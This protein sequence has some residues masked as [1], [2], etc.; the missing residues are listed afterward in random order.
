MRVRKEQLSSFLDFFE[1]AESGRWR[2]H[3]GLANAST[4]ILFN[5]I[6]ATIVVVSGIFGSG[7]TRLC[8]SR[9]VVGIHE[10]GCCHG[11]VSG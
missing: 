1:G 8:I 6:L 10:P 11:R 5:W 2:D 3:L 9:P 7:T 4:L